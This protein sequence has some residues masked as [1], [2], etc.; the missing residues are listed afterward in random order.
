MAAHEPPVI[1]V[2][3]LTGAGGDVA[4]VA[5]AIDAA[6]RDAGFFSVVNHGIDVGLLDRLEALAREFFALPEDEKARVAMAHAGRAWR[7]WF[8]LGGELT[9]GVPDRKEGYYFGE[10]LPADDPR[11]VAGVPL[12]GANLFPAHPAALGPTVLEVMD[13]FTG[14]GHQLMRGLASRSASTRS[15]S[16]A[17]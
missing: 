14:L 2:G 6:C 9:S 3:P 16:T 1:D 8:P 15:G 12:H 10:E 13:R 17:S 7:G 11:V 5:T 4:P